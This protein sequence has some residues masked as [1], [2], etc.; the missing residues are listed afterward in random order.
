MREKVKTDLLQ[1]ISLK[2]EEVHWVKYGKEILINDCLFDIKSFSVQNGVAVFLGLFDFEETVL[3]KQIKKDHQNESGS[4]QITN[5]FKIL[6][7]FYNN[8]DEILTFNGSHVTKK[9]PACISSSLLTPF[10]PLF[11]PPPQV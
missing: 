11:I 7:T 1:T 4:R 2:E 8:T 3:F 6:Q 10:I 9:Y 5:L